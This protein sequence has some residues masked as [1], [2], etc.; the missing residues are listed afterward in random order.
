MRRYQVI[1]AMLMMPQL[2]FSFCISPTHSQNAEI[3]AL[4]EQVHRLCVENEKRQKEKDDQA[5]RKLLILSNPVDVLQP[6]NGRSLQRPVQ[7]L[8]P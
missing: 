1:V 3:N 5:S 2:S 6:N 4:S 7:Q 8:Y